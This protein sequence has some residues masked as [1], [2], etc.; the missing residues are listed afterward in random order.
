MRYQL[1]FVKVLSKRLRKLTIMT[2][3]LHYEKTITITNFLPIIHYKKTIKINNFCD[4]NK[5][6]W[7]FLSASFENGKTGI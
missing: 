4:C 5:R 1:C 7:R 3:R 6:K 2:E